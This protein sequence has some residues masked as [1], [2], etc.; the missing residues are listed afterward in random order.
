MAGRSRR[1]N[2]E[3]ATYAYYET[4]ARLYVSPALGSVARPAPDTDVQAW[5]DGLRYVCQCCAQARTPRG[6]SAASVAA[7]SARAATSTQDAGQSRPPATRSALRSATPAPGE[8]VPRNVA[9]FAAV[10]SP[11]RRRRPGPAWS[12][13]EGSRFLASAVADGD[14]FF[15]A[16][17][18][19]LVNALSKAEALGLTWSSADLAS[20]NSY[21]LAAPAR[22]QPADPQEAGRD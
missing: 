12:A 13:A 10:P 11:R 16:Y 17:I 6:L 3:P 18:L 15:V 22:R 14:P 5:L 4:M 8:L 1:A 7:P 19:V 20:G 21:H 2:L 9:A